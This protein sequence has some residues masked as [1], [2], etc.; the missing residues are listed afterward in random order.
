MNYPSPNLPNRDGTTQ[1]LRGAFRSTPRPPRCRVAMSIGQ[2]S[3]F[4]GAI[5]SLLH[6]RLLFV[7]LLTLAPSLIFLVRNLLDSNL[8]PEVS[9]F[10]R[11][12]HGTV[13]VVT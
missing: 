5:E 1:S 8:P 2:A 7:A 12:F 11:F 9:S 10:G 6:R 4:R 13:A 3:A